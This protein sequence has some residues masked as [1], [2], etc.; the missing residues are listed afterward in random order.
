VLGGFEPLP[1]AGHET[2]EADTHVEFHGDLLS[3]AGSTPAAST[4]A[5]FA[6][7]VSATLPGKWASPFGLAQHAR[8]PPP[9]PSNV[10]YR[11]GFEISVDAIA[12]V[13]PTSSNL[14]AC[15]IA[16]GLTCIY[17]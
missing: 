17:R 1:H 12:T 4:I 15:S 3:D 14:I 8:L 6:R 10:F 2:K 9:P 16:A 5:R 7:S 13:L 11:D